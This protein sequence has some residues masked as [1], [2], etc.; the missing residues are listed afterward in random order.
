MGAG[1]RGSHHL[2]GSA[3]L[4]SGPLAAGGWTPTSWQQAP[5]TAQ[6][7]WITGHGAWVARVTAGGVRSP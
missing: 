4:A 7:S 1:R 5:H 2:G 6:S 3:C